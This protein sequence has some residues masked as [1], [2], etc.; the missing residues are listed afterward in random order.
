MIQLTIGSGDEGRKI[1]RYLEKLLPKAPRSFLF[2]AF[3]QNKVKADGKH[4]KEPDLILKRGMTVSLYLTDE[5]LAEFG[6]TDTPVQTAAATL[7][8][9]DYSGIPILYEDGRILAVSKPAGMLSQKSASGDISLTECM[10]QYLKDRGEWPEGTYEPAFVHRLDRNTSGVMLMAKTLEAARTLSEM[11]RDRRIDKFYLAAV[12]GKAVLWQQETELKDFY[13]KDRQN[14][15]ACVEP[16]SP[17]KES[18]RLEDGWEVCRLKVRC[19]SVKEDVSLLRVELLTGKSHQIR[20]QLSAHGFPILSD[21]KYGGRKTDGKAFSQML[22][23]SEIRLRDCP[24]SFRD[25]QGLRITA[26]IP[27]SFRK[28]FGEEAHL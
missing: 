23:A 14:N 16:Y 25:L 9:P 15:R 28:L 18:A 5:Q 7:Q 27:E 19:L 4:V 12:S 26:K 21:G 3:R 8:V 24:E 17:E 2:R 1:G 10:R 11:V 13:R 22:F 6:Y 20:A